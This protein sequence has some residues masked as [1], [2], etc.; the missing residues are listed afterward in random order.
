M[1]VIEAARWRVCFPCT[2]ARARAVGNRGRCVCRRP[3]E[4][5]KAGAGRRWLSC[6]VCLG[7]VVDLPDTD[8]HQAAQKRGK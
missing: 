2:R 1:G 3:V 6:R 8:R 7:V 4:V 5:E